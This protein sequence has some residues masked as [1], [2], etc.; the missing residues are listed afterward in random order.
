[1]AAAP[2]PDRKRSRR[3][4]RPKYDHL[5]ADQAIDLSKL[6]A[7]TDT[8]ELTDASGVVTQR[9]VRCRFYQI[10]RPDLQGRTARKIPT[11]DLVTAMV[12]NRST[13]DIPDVSVYWEGQEGCVK[14]RVEGFRQFPGRY[15]NRRA[16][17]YGFQVTII[18]SL[19]HEE[20]GMKIDIGLPALGP[21]GFLAKVQNTKCEDVLWR[22]EEWI[23]LTDLGL[24]DIPFNEIHFWPLRKFLSGP[25]PS[26]IDRFDGQGWKGLPVPNAPTSHSNGHE[27]PLQPQPRVRP[28]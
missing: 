10:D 1:M 25:A 21:K 15:R 7:I 2:H 27:H 8:R 18:D 23:P 17:Y 26:L 14:V 12:L 6:A 20:I 4:Q 16:P 9:M 13:I 22:E 11:M 19:L 3:T 5:D 24:P 28:S